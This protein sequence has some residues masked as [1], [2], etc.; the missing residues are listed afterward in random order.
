[1]WCGGVEVGA[2]VAFG[3]HLH[4][5][6][7]TLLRAQAQCEI[8]ARIHLDG[9]IEWRVPDGAHAEAVWPHGQHERV[10]AFVVGGAQLRVGIHANECAAQHFAGGRAAHVAGHAFAARGGGGVGGGSGTRWCLRGQRVCNQS[11]RGTQRQ[12]QERTVHEMD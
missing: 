7:H 10:E 2:L 12:E 8:E 11:R 3:L 9:G 6:Q 4:R 1:M 5:L